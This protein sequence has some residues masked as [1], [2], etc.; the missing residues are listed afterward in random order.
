MEEEKKDIL[1]KNSLV[2]I[3]IRFLKGIAIGIGAIL[4]GLS[5]GVLAVIFGVYNPAIE[6]LGNLRNKFWKNVLFFIPIGIGLLLGIFL[7]SIVVEEA[8]K[9]Y[10]AIFACLFIGFVIGTVPALYKDAGKK[11]RNKTDI[12]L[13]IVT[14]ILLAALMIFGQNLAVNITPSIPV[15]FISGGLV[16]LGFIVPGLSP[17]NFLMYFGLYD[18]MAGGIRVID[19]SVII[20]IA[21]GGIITVLLFSKLISFLLNKYYSK[22][23]HIIL[24]LVLGSSIAIFPTVIVPDFRNLAKTNTDKNLILMIIASVVLFIVGA[25]T[26][27]F[28]SKIEEKHSRD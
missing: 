4:P 28:F 26:T 7:F 14:I 20:P 25:A 3:L 12:I 10:L 8:F 27:Y 19:L 24:G 13:A 21:L 23:K 16:A 6:F 2:D 18:K 22:M 17:S 1:E 9:Q 15:W 11:G 5:G